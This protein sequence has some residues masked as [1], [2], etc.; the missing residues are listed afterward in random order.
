MGSEEGLRPAHG[1]SL[2]VDLYEL[3]MAASY[4]AEGMNQ[5]A[6][7][8]LFFRELPPTRNFLVSCGLEQALAYL[9]HLHFEEPDLAFLRSLGLFS[10][11]F[12]DFLDFVEF[13]GDVWAVPEGEVVFPPAPVL[14]VTAPLIQAQIAETYLLNCLNFSTAV[15]SKAAR[16]TIACEGRPFADFSARRDHGPDAALLAARAAF[17]GGAQSTSNVLAGKQFGIPLSGTMAHSYVLAFPDEA[18]AFRAFARRFPEQAVLLIDTFDTLEGARRAAEVASELAPE[19]IAIRAVRIDSGDLAELAA[20]V[21]RILDGAGH[22]EI[23]ILASGDL[24]EERIAALLDAGAPINGFGVGTRLGTSQDAPSL[25]AVY[26]LVEDP[27]GPKYKRSTGKATLPG[28]KQVWRSYDAAMPGVPAA[29]L[30]APVDEPGPPGARPLL[31][32][33]MQGGRRTGQ[34]PPLLVLRE[35]CRRSVETLPDHL[36]SLGAA[37]AYPVELAP[38]L[39]TEP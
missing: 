13:T 30:I 39:R 23:G 34:N 14:S 16:V 32:L 9:E 21:R 15:A 4:H 36:R 27:T 18:A 19:G 11:D 28:R 31:E 37:P 6:T 8:D 26:K 33:C 10:E 25:G 29:D 35:R 7:F 2:L 22:P 24:D 12:L 3:T 17:V 1:H 5:P 20:G 38:S